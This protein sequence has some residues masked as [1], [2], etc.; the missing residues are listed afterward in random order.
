[1]AQYRELAAFAQFGSDLDPTTKQIL[2]IGQRTTEVLKQGQY[3]PMS[4]ES[5]VAII[6]AVTNGHLEEI[7]IDKVKD[8]EEKFHQ[9]M[10]TQGK[11]VLE[12]IRSTKDL[13][14][15]TEAKLKQFIAD[16]K[17]GYR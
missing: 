14:A 17:Q 5:Q 2:A 13:A 7:S 4:M 9:F 10:K 6:Y 8:F 11:D 16:F 3:R 1:M 15:D 12:E